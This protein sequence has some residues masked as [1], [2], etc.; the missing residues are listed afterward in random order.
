MKSKVS[1][2]TEEKVENAIDISTNFI[3]CCAAAASATLIT[4]VCPPAGALAWIGYQAINLV[5]GDKVSDHFSNKF[6]KASGYVFAVKDPIKE[7]LETVNSINEALAKT[8]EQKGIE[9]PEKKHEVLKFQPIDEDE[10]RKIAA[11]IPNTED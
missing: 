9:L 3:G 7:T 4:A 6:K 2:T 10:L 11:E 1:L 8:A 5:V